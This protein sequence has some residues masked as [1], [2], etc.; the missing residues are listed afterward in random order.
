M[1]IKQLLEIQWIIR[2][3]AN[4]ASIIDGP[5]EEWVI[6]ALN[7]RTVMHGDMNEYADGDCRER[8]QGT[9]ERLPLDVQTSTSMGVT[10][11]RS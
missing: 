1:I 10:V 4:I 7:Q 2:L 8:V 5:A 9:A 6:A 11:P 3:H